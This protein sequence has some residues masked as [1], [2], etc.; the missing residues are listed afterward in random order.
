MIPWSQVA[1]TLRDLEVRAGAMRTLA[2]ADPE[3]FDEPCRDTISQYRLNLLWLK[4]QIE[5][6]LEATQERSSLGQ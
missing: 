4:Q 6:S 5:E 1:L 2:L 3:H